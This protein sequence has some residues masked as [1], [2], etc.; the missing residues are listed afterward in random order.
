MKKHLYIIFLFLPA[1]LMAQNELQKC[2]EINFLKMDSILNLGKD[3][4]VEWHNCMLGKPLP[5]FSLKTMDGEI[6][7]NNAIKGKV[8][9]LSFFSIY[10]APCIAE[11]P[12]LNKL[13]AEYKKKG[14]VFLSITPDK[15]DHLKEYFFPKYKLNFPIVAEAP[16]AI[17]LFGGSGYPKL[18]IINT[19]GNIAELWPGGEFNK[20]DKS[21]MYLNAKPVIDKLIENIT[22]K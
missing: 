7:D 20:T 9:V 6:I 11:L 21:D 17:A 19:E 22:H 8:M 18:F 3:P 1:G 2:M 16:E 10:C 12:G 14:V 13:V 4:F 15:L 5:S